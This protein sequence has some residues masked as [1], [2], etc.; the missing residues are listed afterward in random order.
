MRV[1]VNIYSGTVLNILPY[2]V[3]KQR[4]VLVSSAFMI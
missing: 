3:K 2:L 4:I 1:L